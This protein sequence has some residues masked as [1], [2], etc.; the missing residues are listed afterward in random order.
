MADRA[1]IDMYSGKRTRATGGPVVPVGTARVN[2]DEMGQLL[3]T[4]STDRNSVGRVLKKKNNHRLRQSQATPL[5]DPRKTE[6]ICPEGIQT[7]SITIH[8]GQEVE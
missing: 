2:K 5:L 3:V 7:L 6:L 8:S 1:H 4:G